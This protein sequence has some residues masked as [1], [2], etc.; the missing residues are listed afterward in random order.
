MQSAAKQSSMQQRKIA[1]CL[2]SVV[3][4]PGWSATSSENTKEIVNSVSLC[5]PGPH[6]FIIVVSA[7]ERFTNEDQE[8]LKKLMANFG[9][10]VWSHTL[11][12]FTSGDWL[13][14]K[15]IEEY[16][17]CE[18]NALKWLVNN[19]ESRYHVFDNWRAGSQVKHLQ[20]KLEELVV[21]NKGEH[22]KSEEKKGRLQEMFSRP[23]T[24]TV[25][26]WNKRE[27]E[28]IQKMLKAFWV[29]SDDDS[30]TPNQEKDGSFN[31]IPPTFGEDT[32]SEAGSSC[33]IEPYSKVREWLRK[34]QWRRTSS[35][36]GTE[37]ISTGFNED[38]D[39]N[40]EHIQEV[41][42]LDEYSF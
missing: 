5:P 19:C 34:G 38:E 33:T 35:G 11:V 14:N 30:K 36:Y 24:L 13:K 39:L 17:E 25:D 22:F 23:K 8:A 27:E 4:T 26:E 7:K 42:Y 29:N 32:L 20:I 37:S 1:E 12:L 10:R 31:I 40:Q 6:A 9:E 16:I 3:D 41:D 21:R 18:G 2:I 28:L 15:P